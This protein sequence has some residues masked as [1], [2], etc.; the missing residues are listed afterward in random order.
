MQATAPAAL[1]VVSHRPLRGALLVTLVAATT[2]VAAVVAVD[3]PRS[4]PA[5]V[6]PVTTYLGTIPAVRAAVGPVALDGSL[7]D[8]VEHL[9]QPDALGPD[10]EG[11]AREWKLDG[12]A[13]LS[14]S[15][16]AGASGPIAGVVATIPRSSP[17]R[18][19]LYGGVLLGE[20]TIDEV[21]AAWGAPEARGG[22]D[23]DFNVRYVECSGPYPIV[24]K[25]H[26][27]STFDRVLVG[28]ADEAPG[29]NG[30]DAV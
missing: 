6:A 25:V 23:A 12:G 29:T 26:R 2:L 8:V 7:A 20:A 3:R 24:L 19:G 10:I 17:V 13:L 11:I 15:T 28:Y 14:V 5:P 27:T 18:I 21:I 9:G 4:N 16:P 30:C 22:A 1:P